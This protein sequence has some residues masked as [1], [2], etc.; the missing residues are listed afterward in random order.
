MISF[1]AIEYDS[2]VLISISSPPVSCSS[3]EPGERKSSSRRSV[4]A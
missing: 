2:W 3:H 1:F 4:G